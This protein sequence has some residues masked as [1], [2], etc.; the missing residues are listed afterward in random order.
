MVGQYQ[1]GDQG[2]NNV[3]NLQNQLLLVRLMGCSN[4]TYF[5]SYNFFCYYLSISPRLVILLIHKLGEGLS[6]YLA[7]T[8][9]VNLP[10]CL[11]ALLYHCR[12]L[13]LDRSSGPPGTM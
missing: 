7:F 13:R 10:S 4:L 5:Y 3:G 11:D 6:V 9:Q 8:G 12:G 1:G 2:K